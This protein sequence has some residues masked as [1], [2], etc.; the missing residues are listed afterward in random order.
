MTIHQYAKTTH[1][2]VLAVIAA[3]N[4]AF[5]EFRAKLGPLSEKYTGSPDNIMYSGSSK[6]GA[7]VAGIVPSDK[8]L[9][10][11]WKKPGKHGLRVPYRNNPAYEDFRIGTRPAPIPGRPSIIF[12]KTDQNGT[13]WMS[14]GAV[15]EH[16]GAAYSGVGF[17]PDPNRPTRIN[18]VDFDMDEYGWHEIPAS[19]FNTA[20]DAVN[21]PTKE[22]PS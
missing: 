10:G 8:P 19:E 11:Q 5:D 21:A 12:G 4:A 7:G 1:P 3:N 13:A 22:N 2:E 14:H 6:D 18:G 17:A 15:F 16:E 9:P 20:M